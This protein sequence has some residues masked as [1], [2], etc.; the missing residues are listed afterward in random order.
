MDKISGVI[1]TKNNQKNISQCL[2]Q[3][4]ALINELII[5]DDFSSD[6]TLS[7]VRQEYP[8][9][10]IIQKKLQRFDDQ[11]NYGLDISSNDWVLMIDSDEIITSELSESIKMVKDSDNIDGYWVARNNKFFSTY[12]LEKN[13]ERLILF[14]KNL[15]F[16]NPVHEVIP[17][18]NKRV[19]K[20][21]G[22]LLH[23]DD[24]S[25][26]ESM[27]RMNKY[28]SL[29]AVKWLEQER[30]YSNFKLVILSFCLPLFFFL[31]CFFK[32]KFYKAGFFVGLFYAVIEASSWLVVIFK[33]RELRNIK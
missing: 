23:E 25:I 9:A 1:L 29:I 21:K 6:Q 20:L 8:T 17:R 2:R 13:P 22:V 32:K 33:Y 10:K 7:I 4:S 30:N 16:V 12:L 28:S 5:I 15:R 26:S 31:I 3:V 19:L 14:R 27:D 24:R 11:R 18:D